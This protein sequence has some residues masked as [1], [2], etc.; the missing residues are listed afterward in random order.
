M[1]NGKSSSTTKRIHRILVVDGMEL[2]RVGL[3]KILSAA[4][5]FVV[6]A[7]TGDYED[8]PELLKR[9]RPHVMIVEPFHES[10]YGI[11]WIKE[12][13]A[14]YPRTKILVASSNSEATYAERALRAGASGYWMKNGPVDELFQAIETVLGGEVYVSAMITSLAMHKFAGHR[15]VPYGLDVLSD[16]EMEVFRTHCGWARH[17]SDRERTWHQ[18]QDGGEPFSAHQSETRLFPMPKRC[19]AALA[20][21]WSQPQV[22]PRVPNDAVVASSAFGW[23]RPRG[24]LCRGAVMGGIPAT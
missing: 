9:H 10:R 16:R 7:A 11:R 21:C 23:T 13:A 14:E 1:R 5:S 2:V 19:I 22:H 3:A 8:V 15:E 24:E 6:C 4:S 20:N 17:Q 12:L 18:W